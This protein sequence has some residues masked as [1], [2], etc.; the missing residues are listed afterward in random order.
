MKKYRVAAALMILHGAC[1]E[2]GG[3]LCILPCL[4]LD[5]LPFDI[6]SFF[7]FR[8]PYFQEN[9]YLISVTGAIYGTLRL[10]GAVGLLKNRMWGLAL[11]VI[12]CVM[13][14]LLMMFLL[15]AGIIDGLLAGGAL[16]L[17]L[18]SYFGEKKI[19]E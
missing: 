2:I 11:S 18:P 4:L 6:D 15:P 1:M 5:D 17:I 14:L 10:I 19:Q 13:T 8:L 7:S 3:F 9:L 12:N 16:L